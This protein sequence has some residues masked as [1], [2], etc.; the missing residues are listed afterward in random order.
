MFV[1]ACIW[2]V[3][4]AILAIYSYIYYDYNH[5]FVIIYIAI[6]ICFFKDPLDLLQL[7]IQ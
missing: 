6:A 1:H 3:P 2:A 4:T 5:N 7:L